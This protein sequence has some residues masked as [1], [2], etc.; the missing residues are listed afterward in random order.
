MICQDKEGKSAVVPKKELDKCLFDAKVKKINKKFSVCEYLNKEVAPIK[1]GRNLVRKFADLHND[2][3]A[4]TER[5][6]TRLEDR[7]DYLSYEISIGY[8]TAFC[9]FNEEGNIEMRDYNLDMNQDSKDYKNAKEVFEELILAV[10]KLPHKTFSYDGEGC[11]FVPNEMCYQIDSEIERNDEEGELFYFQGEIRL[12]KHPHKSSNR[13]GLR[14][15]SVVTLKKRGIT[16]IGKSELIERLW[17]WFNENV[18]PV[19]I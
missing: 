2:V 15:Y 7:S 18:E 9:H 10:E 17:V 1:V 8:S 19:M 12:I 3:Y 11:F 5:Y 4:L 14:G 16:E 13:Y 6:D